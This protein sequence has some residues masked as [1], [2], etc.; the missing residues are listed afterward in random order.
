MSQEGKFNTFWNKFL[1][2]KSSKKKRFSELGFIESI[3][4]NEISG[5]FISEDNSLNKIG[6][7]HSNKLL[8]ETSIN[9]R[10]VDVSEKYNFLGETGFKLELDQS[11]LRKLNKNVDPYFEVRAI[12]EEGKPST[13]KIKSVQNPELTSQMLKSS[14]NTFLIGSDGYLEGLKYDGFIYGWISSNNLNG[15]DFIWVH[16]LQEKPVAIKCNI[17]RNIENLPNGYLAKG[18][19]INPSNFTNNNCE[20]RIWCSFDFEGYLKLPSIEDVIISQKTFSIIK[21][22]KNPFFISSERSD[23]KWGDLN[24]ENINAWDIVEKKF[25][26]SSDEIKEQKEILKTWKKYIVDFEK[27]LMKLE[28][29]KKRH[30]KL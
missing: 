12:N 11:I 7:F 20:K 24:K 30:S 9:I 27:E 23:S 21:H 18:F 29:L 16:G 25:P 17:L 22:F 10:R 6:L 13:Y 8:K 14:L 1:S 15:Q 4:P 2:K 5:W 19:Q 3:L 28:N 26:F